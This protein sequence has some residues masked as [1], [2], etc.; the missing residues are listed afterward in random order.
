MRR[1][2]LRLHHVGNQNARTAIA[3]EMIAASMAS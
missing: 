3:V 2:P 1:P